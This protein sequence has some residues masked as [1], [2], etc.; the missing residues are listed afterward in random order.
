MDMTRMWKRN[1]RSGGVARVEP[2]HDLQL[3]GQEVEAAF[4]EAR[5]KDRVA[6][7]HGSLTEPLRCLSKMNQEGEEG[8]ELD[9]HPEELEGHEGE[10]Q[11]FVVPPNPPRTRKK[12]EDQA[13]RSRKHNSHSLLPN[14]QRYPQQ[15]RMA[16]DILAVPMSSVASESAFSLSKKVITPNRSSLKPKTVETLMCL[17]DW[18][19]CKLQKK[20]DSKRKEDVVN[21][22]EEC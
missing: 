15:A 9:Y 22:D 1:L 14:S 3:L 21:L 13:D 4:P 20:E 17:Q 10:I 6:V 12:R 5:I 11:L 18:Y 19:R 7:E 2:P 16:R 8:D